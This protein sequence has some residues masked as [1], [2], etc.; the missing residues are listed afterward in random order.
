MVFD[1]AALT[2]IEQLTEL[3]ISYLL[4][5]EGSLDDKDRTRIIK[6]L[7]GYFTDNLDKSIFGYVA[8]EKQEIVSCVLLVISQK[9]M[10]PH[11]IT[12]KVGTVCNVYTKPEYRHKGYAHRLMEMVTA[13]AVEKDLS[14]M[15]LKATEDGYNLYKSVG[16]ND[17]ISK[18]HPM[19]WR[20]PHV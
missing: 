17:D 3:R 9:P 16:F 2:D 12:G 15:E 10:G 19:K 7:P 8:R 6:G 4:E 1:R 11:F 13:D 20:N 14:V 5:D 18:Y